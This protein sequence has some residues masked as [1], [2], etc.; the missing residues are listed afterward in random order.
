[1]TVGME[2]QTFNRA[3]STPLQADAESLRWHEQRLYKARKR[4]LGPTSHC[5]L[6]PR[7]GGILMKRYFKR[8]GK[9]RGIRPTGG[10]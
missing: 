3:Y 6:A 9:P 10:I 8:R 4:S 2:K 5:P 1:M 7:R